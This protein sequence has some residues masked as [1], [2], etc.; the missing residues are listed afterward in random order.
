MWEVSSLE[1]HFSVSLRGSISGSGQLSYLWSR[2]MSL[3]F[4]FS[5]NAPFV[6]LFYVWH[7]EMIPTFEFLR[8]DILERIGPNWLVIFSSFIRKR[9]GCNCSGGVC[10]WGNG[11]SSQLQSRPPAQEGH[12]SFCLQLRSFQSPRGSKENIIRLHIITFYFTFPNKM[13]SEI[14]NVCLAFSF[15]SMWDL[16]W[17]LQPPKC[18]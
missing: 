5:K 8:P 4:L 10:H 15:A 9:I 2:C 18:W 12:C 1:V 3:F 14:K 16:K 7:L 11:H 6:L 17:I 13:S